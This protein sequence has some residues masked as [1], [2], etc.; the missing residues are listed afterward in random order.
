MLFCAYSIIQTLVPKDINR[1]GREKFQQF[2][3]LLRARVRPPVYNWI[4]LRRVVWKI[5]YLEK[6]TICQKLSAGI[7][8]TGSTKNRVVKPLFVPGLLWL[9]STHDWT[10]FCLFFNVLKA[11]KGNVHFIWIEFPLEIHDWSAAPISAYVS[12]HVS[13]QLS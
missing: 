1:Y 8:S 5:Y 11:S 12:L 3:V 13:R 7:S 9:T 6:V 2:T 10:A 4:D